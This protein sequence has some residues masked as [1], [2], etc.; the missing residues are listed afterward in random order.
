M[1]LNNYFSKI[2]GEYKK[3]NALDTYTVNPNMIETVSIVDKTAS[4]L[5][6]A[7]VSFVTNTISCNI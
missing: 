4:G 3:K 2:L 7:H 1:T 6:F 5:I